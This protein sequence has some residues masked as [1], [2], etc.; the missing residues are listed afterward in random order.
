MPPTV[1]TKFSLSNNWKFNARKCPITCYQQRLQMILPAF[2]CLASGFIT[3][4]CPLNASI[5]MLPSS[6]LF[7]MYFWTMPKI[8]TISVHS[9][10]FNL[11]SHF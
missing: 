5:K 3:G 11:N 1:D 6:L 4:S 7:S 2:K 9:E 10:G 8:V